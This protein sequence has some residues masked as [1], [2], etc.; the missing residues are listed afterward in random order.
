MVGSGVAVRA[1]GI[2]LVAA[3]AL[4]L[5]A[6]AR[7]ESS[8]PCAEAGA[9]FA[10][11]EAKA[12]RDGITVQLADGREV[13]LA[14]VVAANGL[15]GDEQAVRGATQALHRLVAG[16]MLALHGRP[17]TDRYGRLVA[18][19][20]FAD[21][22]SHWV[23]AALVSDGIV[24]VAPEAG[25]PACSAALIAIEQK[26]RAAHAGLWADGRFGVQKADDLAALNAAAGRFA[27]VEGR[28]T[29]VGESGQ[30][31]FLDFGRRYTED[32]TL[33]VSREA[34][35]TFTA[36]GIDLKTM[37]GKKVRVRGVLFPWGGPAIELRKPAA[38]ELIEGA[39]T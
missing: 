32:F 14:G 1:H 27:V 23:Q 12:A 28:I 26:A 10:T 5:I 6:P 22:E 24:R 4:A 36:A 39:G 29:R 15:D 18:Q 11:I 7:A 19:A 20:A 9:A 8:A 38:F 16:R 3:A 13:R 37:K 35:Q 33:V 17:G 31:L 21:P 25:E 30:R 34:R 2:G